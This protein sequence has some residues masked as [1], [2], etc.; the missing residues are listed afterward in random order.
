M[1]LFAFFCDFLLCPVTIKVE[2]KEAF[3]T[4]MLPFWMNPFGT[5]RPPGRAAVGRCNDNLVAWERG[6]GG[7]SF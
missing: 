4:R 7:I 2:K 5:G 3:K 6:D 1:I